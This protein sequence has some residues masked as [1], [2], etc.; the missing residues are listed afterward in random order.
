MNSAKKVSERL[1]KKYPNRRLYDTQTSSYITLTDVKQLVLDSEEFTVVD[2]KTSEDLTRSILLQIILEEE[3]GGMPMFSYEVLTQ[4]IRFYGQAMQGVMGPFLEKNLQLFAQMQQKLQESS[5]YF[6]KALEVNPNDP[7]ARR[8]LASN[9]FQLGQL[10]SARENLNRV[11]KARPADKTAILL[12]GMV[13]E[14]LKDYS[15]AIK[16]LESVP[17]QVQ[18]RPKSIAALARSYYHTNQSQKAKELLKSLQEHPA[19]AEGVFL[20]AQVAAALRDYETAELLFAS[21][22]TT[23]SDAAR[24]GTQ[25][26]SHWR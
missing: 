10:Q 18:E 7:A 22:Q 14:E 23:Y 21:I 16:W 19:G 24:L 20:G 3:N 9:Q 1:I 2:A 12:R 26:S 4:F 5:A 25:S 8:N 13:A 17:D 15:D 6:D 11:L